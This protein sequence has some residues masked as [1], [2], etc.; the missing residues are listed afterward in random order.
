MVTG[1]SCN[2]FYLLNSQSFCATSKIKLTFTKIRGE[3]KKI[4]ILI[5]TDIDYRK[6]LRHL[7]NFV[8]Y[9]DVAFRL[10][11]VNRK[12]MLERALHL[13]ISHTFCLEN[14]DFSAHTILLFIASVGS[15]GG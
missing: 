15:P 9:L 2:P 1:G 8:T 11:M 3:E 5:Q 4:Q 7:Q 10:I 12:I 6:I 14:F 13:G